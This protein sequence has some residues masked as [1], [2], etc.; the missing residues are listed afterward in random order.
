MNTEQSTSAGPSDQGQSNE[1]QGHVSD[2]R[3]VQTRQPIPTNWQ[4]SYYDLLA[5][6]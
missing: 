3:K 6:V 2:P 1:N 5:L 4:Q